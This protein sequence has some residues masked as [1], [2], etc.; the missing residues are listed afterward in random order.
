MKVFYTPACGHLVPRIID[1]VVLAD[2]QERGQFSGK[3]LAELTD[4]Y[5]T[6]CVGDL[7][8]VTRIK[9]NMMRTEPESCTEEQFWEALECLPPEGWVRAG[10]GESF[11]M[12]ERLSGRMTTIYARSGSTYWSFVDADDL[13]HAAIMAKVTAAIRGEVVTS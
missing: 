8:D 9:E 12:V 1:T 6:V 2:G 4:K 7:D 13:T 11:K 10:G 5:P 3:T